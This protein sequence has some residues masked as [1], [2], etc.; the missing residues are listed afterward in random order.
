MDKPTSYGRRFSIMMSEPVRKFQLSLLVLLLL[1]GVGTLGYMLLGDM[2]FVDALYM[3]VITIT[4]VGFAEIQPLQEAGRIFTIGLIVLG[5]GASAWAIRNGAE[6][7][8]GETLW[9]SVHRRT[10]DKTIA[11]LNNH[12]IICGYGRMGRQIVHDLR[13]RNESFVVID[14]S[15]K[16]E[17]TLIEENIPY[18]IGDATHD[19]VLEHAGIQNARGL[20]SALDTDADNVLAALTARGLNSNLL[21]VARA[22]NDLSESKLRR[23]GADRVVSPYAIGGHRLALALLQPTVHDFFNRMFNLEEENVDIGEI[24]IHENSR[25]AGQTI[26]ECDIR[27]GWNLII[28]GIRRESGDFT[29]GPDAKHILKPG[30]TLIVIGAPEAIYKL[31][32]R[33]KKANTPD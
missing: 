15:S 10:M 32:G 3:T 11:K 1:I 33:E 9:Y 13:A 28:L 8:L 19:D 7:V 30:E 5:V 23:A 18:I 17:E 29:I 2:G 22:I 25:L 20:V 16:V 31:Q 4:T 12:Y 26:A 21:I 27:H 14:Q 6:V 24:F